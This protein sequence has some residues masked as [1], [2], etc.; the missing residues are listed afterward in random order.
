MTVSAKF[1]CTSVTDF[2]KQ[3]QA[4]FMAVYGTDGE[5]ADYSKYTPS[6]DLS[7]TIDKETPAFS[8]FEPQKDYYLL[9][10]EVPTLPEPK[11]VLEINL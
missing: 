10:E 9:F 3:K 2:G 1:R 6:G 7:I 11:R 8:F 5:N 4:K